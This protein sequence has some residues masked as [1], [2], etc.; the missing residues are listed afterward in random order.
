MLL[1]GWVMLIKGCAR[2]SGRRF[3]LTVR[4]PVQ[5]PAGT[6][7]CGVCM[8]SPSVCGFSLSTPASSH[9]PKSP[10]CSHLYLKWSKVCMWVCV[11]MSMW[12]C[13]R[14]GVLHLHPTLAEL[15]PSA[16]WLL[17]GFSRYHG[18]MDLWLDAF[19]F[20]GG[21]NTANNWPKIPNNLL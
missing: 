6:F 13:N 3:C 12:H 5:I 4:V 19:L 20:H 21:Q 11:W 9:C 8:F 15:A 16:L 10:A 2:G 1:F 17:K 7:L 14:L 18:C